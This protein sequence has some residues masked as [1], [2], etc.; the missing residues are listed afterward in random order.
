MSPWIL[1]RRGLKGGLRA[2]AKFFV[3]RHKRERERDVLRDTKVQYCCQYVRFASRIVR[4]A[5]SLF[6]CGIC[7]VMGDENGELRS[8]LFFITYHFITNIIPSRFGWIAMYIFC[9]RDTV[10]CYFGNN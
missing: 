7:R 4:S 10:I 8:V 3:I 6:V 5:I 2:F 9:F 1:E